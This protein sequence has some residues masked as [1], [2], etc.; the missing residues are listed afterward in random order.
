MS[1]FRGEELGGVPGVEG[2]GQE[3][4][5]FRRKFDFPISREISEPE[6]RIQSPIEGPNWELRLGAEA[7]LEIGKW[8][9]RWAAKEQP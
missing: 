6:V 5:G 1:V 4:K 7:S 2:L 8:K 3:S 9:F